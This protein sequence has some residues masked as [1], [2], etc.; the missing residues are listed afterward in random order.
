MPLALGYKEA[1]RPYKSETLF[2]NIWCLEYY[3]KKRFLEC[4]KRTK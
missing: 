3:L 2:L 1:R 4:L